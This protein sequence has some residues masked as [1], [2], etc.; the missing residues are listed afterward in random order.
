MISNALRSS[1]TPFQWV[2]EFRYL[3]VYL[4]VG[5]V[6]SCSF[7][8]AKNSFFRLL[9]YILSKVRRSVSEEVILSLIKSIK[10]L[11]YPRCAVATNFSSVARSLKLSHVD[12]G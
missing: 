6:F 11:P 9:N 2:S 10:C 12:H 7:T 4:K 3:G 1:G 8:M 5:R